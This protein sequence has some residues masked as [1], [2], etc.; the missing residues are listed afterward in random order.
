MLINRSQT[1]RVSQGFV[2]LFYLDACTLLAGYV[3]TKALFLARCV[4]VKS[5]MKDQNFDY[6][7]YRLASENTRRYVIRGIVP[8]L[9]IDD[10]RADLVSHGCHLFKT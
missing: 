4:G 2:W 7:T 1:L 5:Y 3:V 6:H 8:E 9:D 10:I